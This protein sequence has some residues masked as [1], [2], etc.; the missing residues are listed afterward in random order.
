MPE[1]PEVE[2]V[3][4][5]LQQTV[6]GHTI[7]DAT[8]LLPKTVRH[9]SP[10]DFSRTVAGC[11][12][13]TIHRRGKYL[14]IFLSGS[15]CLVVHLRMTGRFDYLPNATPC[16]PHTRVILHLDRG[17][18]LRFVDMRTFGVMELV[19]ADAWDTL[20]GL[21]ALGP[22]PDS[23]E[24]NATYLSEK[25]RN[26][27]LPVKAFL[28]NQTVVAGVGNI[29]ADESL[30]RARIHP[31]SPAGC[32]SLPDWERLSQAIRETLAD[33]ITH[34]GTSVQS[35][36]N[37]DGRPGS[38]QDCLQVYQ[39]T[40]QPCPRCGTL[41]IKNRTAGRGTHFCPACQSRPSSSG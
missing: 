9:A 21:A 18:D 35:Y 7:M 8:V 40:G 26:R 20:P 2:T 24:F 22:E 30:F 36:L 15:W 32:L 4:Q 13:E 34:R 27:T 12:I 6:V 17:W 19:A 37:L 14:L 10:E 25:A 11:R 28:L 5:G 3:R 23:A 31:E 38:Y 16:H 1:L 39:Q 29:Y 41:I 33:G